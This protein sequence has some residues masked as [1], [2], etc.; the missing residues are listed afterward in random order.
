MYEQEAS[1]PERP[2]IPAV[3]YVFIAIIACEYILLRLGNAPVYVPIICVVVAGFMLVTYR[4]RGKALPWF[5]LV[6]LAA[7]CCAW[8]AS[9]V[10][11]QSQEQSIALLDSMPVSQ[12]KLITIGDASYKSYSW[13]LRAEAYIDDVYVGDVWLNSY[14]ELDRGLVLTGIGSFNAYGS[15][16]WDSSQ[17]MR[18]IYGTVRL[19]RINS[20]EQE[21]GLRG[22]IVAF[23]SY[24]LGIL[25]ASS[26][27]ERALLAG[28]IC[29][30][31]PASDELGLTELFARC[32]IAHLVAVSGGHLTMV[33]SVVRSMLLRLKLSRAANIV[34]LILVT[35]IFVLF[36]GAP[37]SA[38]R[39]WIM[40]LVSYG[41]IIAGRREHAFSSICLVG[42]VMYLV[43]PKNIGDVGLSLSIASLIGIRLLGDY[44]N[45]VSDVL[46]R[47]KRL[48]SSKSAVMRWLD[49]RLASI[50]KTISSC[51][52][53][54][55][56]TAPI[57]IPLFS[58]LSLIAPLANVVLSPLLNL[59][60][61]LGMFAV[62]FC[63]I[64][65]VGTLLLT[66][67]DIYLY[68]VLQIVQL[69]AAI[70]YSSIV[71]SIS[72]WIC[73]TTVICIGAFIFLWWPTVKRRYLVRASIAIL[74]IVSTIY[75]RARWFA[76]ARI[77]VLDVGQ[78]DAILI[79]DGASAILIDTGPDDAV[80]EALAQESVFHLDAVVITHMH[81]DH[82]G[83]LDDLIDYIEVDQVIVGFGAASNIPNELDE[84]IESLVD[85]NVMEL[86]YGDSLYV[87]NY[88]LT[89]L[90]PTEAR[91]GSENEDSLVLE[92]SYTKDRYSLSGL[93]TGDAES[94]VLDAI[95]SQDG[96]TDID[97]LKIGHHGA[98]ASITSE[99][100]KLLLP[101][102][103]VASAGENNSYGH[104]TSVCID[105][106][107]AA[108]STV[109][110]TI[111]YGNIEITP[112]YNGITVRTSKH[113]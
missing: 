2:Y 29:G 19:T 17:R 8:F 16:E 89:C 104:P 28:L 22:S 5:P 111:D 96:L 77:V 44:A 80:L 37:L 67:C 3:F 34:V 109:L 93:L 24:L 95:D 64:P 100:A 55:I 74:L 88:V 103:S 65:H 78:G 33:A 11:L 106:L 42:S 76:P 52:V 60:I 21:R 91:D 83:G 56:S 87:G 41:A 23:R 61:S 14:E 59:G 90:S 81:N 48:H 79:Q 82:Y 15:G 66:L 47:C 36:C 39:S 50:S 1:P 40:C 68:P 18:G 12:W 26:S 102:L 38:V 25:D 54:Q 75:L 13:Q 53:A 105:V 112:A 57:V 46:L 92:I 20:T 63:W 86:A 69:C 31:T 32:G 49:S 45:Y 27:K 9:T 110:C 108:G 35:G 73:W 51:V 94:D 97:F 70:P 7:I 72:A 113:A 85:D 107:E 71:L 10:F 43:A 30:F 101:E 62:M 6:L 84:A 98:E 4:H 58:R 99:Q